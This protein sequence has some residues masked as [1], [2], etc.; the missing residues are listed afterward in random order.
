VAIAETISAHTKQYPLFLAVLLVF[1]LTIPTG[2]CQN[3]GTIRG[4]V[5]DQFNAVIPDVLVGL[6]STDRVLQVKSGRN[7]RFEFT[8]T[9]SG[10]YELNASHPGFQTR[11]IES[12]RIPVKDAEA[13]SIILLVAAQPSE[14]GMGPSATYAKAAVGGPSLAGVVREYAGQPLPGFK[15]RLSKTDATQVLTSQRSNER[16]EFQFR[17][18]EPSQYVLRASHKGYRETQSEA[19]WITREN[20]TRIIFEPVKGTGIII[21]Q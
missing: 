1:L 15:I 21:C 6:Y 2:R 17:D 14:G 10:T 18:V 16:G 7:G 9:P 11:R 12:I 20:I 13:I 4:V 5:T 19:F 8:D 3:N